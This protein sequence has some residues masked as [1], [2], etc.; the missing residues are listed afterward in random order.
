MSKPMTTIQKYMTSA[1]YSI[2]ADQTLAA[3][4]RMMARHDVRHLP[5]LEDGRLLG[6]LTD[7]D[8]KFVETFPD[9]D[10]STLSVSEAM[11]EEPYSVAP[12]TPLHEV[13]STMANEKIGSALVVRNHEVIGIFTSVDACRALAGLLEK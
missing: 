2:D 11:I 7:R 8:L 10:P 12:D 1:P 4:S 9:V 5:V 3:A 13:V 6:V